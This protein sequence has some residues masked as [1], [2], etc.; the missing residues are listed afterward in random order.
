[1]LAG[2]L[3]LGLA[4]RFLTRRTATDTSPSTMSQVNSLW[5]RIEPLADQL[6]GLVRST[7][8]TAPVEIPTH[9]GF[10]LSMFWR[11]LRLYD[12][13]LV[14]LK[15]E[16]PEESAFLAR[17]LFEDSLRLKQLQE[18]PEARIALVLGWVNRSLNEKR[19]LMQMAKSIG[20]DE[21]IA[22]ALAA[23]ENDR[24]KL[25]RYAARHSVTALRS[26]LSVKAAA[27]RYGRK[28]D[29][30]TY[31]WAHES[32]HGS[33]A[34]YMFSRKKLA[35]QTAGMHAKTG[36]PE[37]LASFAEFAA[38]SVTEAT[39]SAFAIL[40]WPPPQGLSAPA[41]EMRA[42]LDEHATRHP[43]PN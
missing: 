9:L 24:A 14:L 23:I 12:G 40:D 20:L 33:D 37:I 34:A 19:G 13:I 5:H 7:A 41:D 30:W 18:E 11:C 17:S 6:L 15:S 22:G 39:L 16:L 29:F 2:L 26:F 8:S 32:V 10:V 28:D 27:I 43:K 42:I 3:L 31:E 36:D 25:L 4:L 1:V 35:D 38:R 21:D